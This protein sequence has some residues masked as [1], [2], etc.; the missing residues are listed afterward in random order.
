MFYVQLNKISC[1]LSNSSFFCCATNSSSVFYYCFPG[2]RRKRVVSLLCWMNAQLSSQSLFY[3][4]EKERKKLKIQKRYYLLFTVHTAC[5]R[6]S[7]IHFDLF[8]TTFSFSMFQNLIPC[9]L[10][11]SNWYRSCS[12]SLHWYSQ[13]LNNNWKQFALQQGNFIEFPL[14]FRAKNPNHETNF[15]AS[16]ANC[17]GFYFRS[18]LCLQWL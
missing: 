6:V 9:T 8:S 7:R 15:C 16:I 2:H 14:P 17:N 1:F 13:E 4:N 3:S 12:S 5:C 18:V 10:F 11:N